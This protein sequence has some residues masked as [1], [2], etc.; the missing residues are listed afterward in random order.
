MPTDM[1]SYRVFISSPGGLES[2]RRVVHDTI[3]AFNQE[4][5]IP[6][7]VLF[8]PVGW[9]LTPG[10][11]ARPQGLI[12]EDVRECDYFVLLLQDRWRTKPGDVG[13]LPG[14]PSSDAEEE[15]ELA[16]DCQR[17]AA[18]PMRQLLVCFKPPRPED[19]ASMSFQLKQVLDFRKRLELDHEHPYTT[20][21][22]GEQLSQDVRRR[23]GLW[24][25]DHEEKVDR[26]AEAARERQEAESVSA[27]STFSYEM[28]PD[29]ADVAP[30]LVRAELIAE[31]KR[32]ADAGRAA[33]AESCFAL[34]V[35]RGDDPGAFIE[36]GKFLRRVGRLEQARE[37]FE[38]ALAF[39][40]QRQDLDVMAAAYSCLG[41]L[42]QLKGDLTGAEAMHRKGFELQKKRGDQKGLAH[43]YANMGLVSKARGD[44][45][46]AELML[47]RALGI[48][49]KLGRLH[50]M[51]NQYCNLGLISRR[52][53]DLA[54][55]ED[56]LRRALEIDEKLGRLEAMANGYGNIGLVLKARGDLD[57][58]EECLR[59]AL[60]INESLGRL[61]GLASDYG[62][63]GLICQK[64][65]RLDEAEKMHLTSLSIE[66]QLGRVE[67]M[68]RSHYSLGL[69]AKTRGDAGGAKAHWLRARDLFQQIGMPRDV[70][71]MEKALAEAGGARVG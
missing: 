35:A 41:M 14:T 62:N 23:L 45:V 60:T 64:R 19:L 48:E 61:E 32:L 68:A 1:H 5:A 55:A 18:M 16:Q 24:L 15:F 70:R 30:G 36:Y 44:L 39:A 51:A 38:K 31:G 59:R 54:R 13:H 47:R 43:A 17:D 22:T 33:G 25:R 27:G 40:S 7:G 20:F 37:M 49:E 53:G 69:L 6:R 34:A 26:K 28:A 58:A 10:G 11:A 4:Q 42:L 71:L 2:E 50:G 57:G 8:V 29:D 56:M 66:E 3:V 21:D 67:G 63:L 12:N 46:Q 65:G 52:L 9:Q